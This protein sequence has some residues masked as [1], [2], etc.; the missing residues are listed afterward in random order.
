MDKRVGVIHEG[1]LAQYHIRQYKN[2]QFVARLLSYNGAK[3]DTPPEELEIHKEG[4]HWED[5]G[6]DQN[7]VDELGLAIESETRLPEQP[8]Y[9]R[10]GDSRDDRQHDSRPGGRP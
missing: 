7:L 3:E 1:S 8:I 5:Q 9:N 6:A 4:R 10:R 2:G